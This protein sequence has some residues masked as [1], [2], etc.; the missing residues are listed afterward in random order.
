[1]F[2]ILSSNSITSYFT[3][4]FYSATNEKTTCLDNQELVWILKLV[5]LNGTDSF[6]TCNYK[7]YIDAILTN[8][9]IA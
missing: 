9:S 3:V 6:Q 5:Y 2:S 4:L 8:I 1:M 7:V